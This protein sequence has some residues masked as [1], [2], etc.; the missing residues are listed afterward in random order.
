MIRKTSVSPNGKQLSLGD[1]VRPIVGSNKDEGIVVK[2]RLG[3]D[4]EDHGGIHVWQLNQTGYGADNCEHY[5]EFEWWDSLSLI[6]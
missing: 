1:R 2:I 4:V 3:R 6:P 5:V